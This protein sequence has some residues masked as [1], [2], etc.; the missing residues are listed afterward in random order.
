LLALNAAVEAA[1]AG[2]QGRGFAVV[3]S[4]VRNLAQRSAE[5]AKEIKNLIEDSVNKVTE[6]TKLVNESGETLKEIVDAVKK[7]SDIVSEISAASQEQSS[8][9]H[10]VNKA[11]SQMDEMTQ[12]NAALVQEATSASESVTDQARSLKQQVE[13]F[14]IGEQAMDE[15]REFN[16]THFQASRQKHSEVR[17]HVATPHLTQYRQKSKVEQQKTS[18]QDSKVQKK[19][20]LS[21]KES[22]DGDWGDF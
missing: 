8:G 5:A 6:G 19:K 15:L 16:E 18:L 1:R 11:V 22:E 3:A 2:E 13:F 20:P 12:Q 17:Q 9:I 4:E 21:G 7:V 14:K 10:Q